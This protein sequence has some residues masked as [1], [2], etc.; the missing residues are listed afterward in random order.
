MASDSASPIASDLLG[1]NAGSDEFFDDVL[2]GR[3]T[4]FR[5]I[6]AHVGE[7]HLRTAFVFASLP[8]GSDVFDEAVDLGFREIL[9]RGGKHPGVGGEFAAVGGDIQRVIDTR[10]HLLRPQPV[11]AF[12]QLLLEGILFIG[13]R[14]GNDDRLAALQ[15]GPWQVEHFGRLHIGESPEHLLEFRQVGEAGEAAAWP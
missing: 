14:A 3:V 10:V 13:H 12:H 6:D 1:R 15:A 8:D 11:V 9:C 4:P 7:Y 2:V 5:R